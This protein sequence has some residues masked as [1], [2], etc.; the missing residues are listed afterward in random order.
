MRS[1][2]SFIIISTILLRYH[3]TNATLSSQ[4]PAIDSVNVTYLKHETDCDKFYKCTNGR[5]VLF[6]CP[7]G[8]QFNLQLGVCDYPANVN[9]IV[10]DS[11]VVNSE[12]TTNTN[13]P[14]PSSESS[15]AGK[16]P[17]PSLTQTVANVI[18]T[19]VDLILP[20]E[21]ST[22]PSGPSVEINTVTVNPNQP[23]V[24]QELAVTSDSSNPGVT[25]A[26]V[27]G[28]ISSQ[29]VDT[30]ATD[31]SRP[32]GPSNANPS[33]TVD[34]QEPATTVGNIDPTATETPFSDT[35]SSQIVDFP[36]NQ[37][38]VG[39]TNTTS[40]N[41][42]QQQPN[43]AAN[44]S[45]PAT[46]NSTQNPAVIIDELN[47]GITNSPPVESTGA[48]SPN[49]AQPGGNPSEQVSNVDQQQPSGATEQSVVDTPNSTQNPAVI[50]DEL[51]PGI[52]NSPPVE[53]TGAGSPNV[54]Q[55]GGNPS[56]QA[57]NVDQQQ[58]SGATEQS[59]VDTPNS[60]QTPAEIIDELNP[61]ITNSLPVES[62]AAGSPNVAQ[63]GG[64]PSEQVS[65]VDQQQPS[66]ATEQSVVDTPNSTQNPAVIIDELNPGITNIPPAES[67]AAG[68]P[69]VAQPGGN[70]SEQVSNVDQQQPNGAS[71]QLVT[72]IPNS[73]QNPAVIIDELNPGITNSPPAE[74]TGAGSPNVAQPGSNPSEQVSNVD[75]QQP[76]VATNQ[77]IAANSSA[78]QNPGVIIDELNP[79]VSGGS[80]V[81][82]TGTGSGNAAQSGNPSVQAPNV[83]QQQPSVATNQSVAANSSTSQNPGVIIDELNPGVS[84]GSLVNS[85]ATGS[86]NAAQPGSNPSVQAPNVDQQ[87]PSVA[88]N[89][90]VAANSSASQNPGAII[91]ELNPGVS[92]GS[93]VNSTA[94]GSGN[95]AQPGSNPSVQ[96]PNV[97]QQQPSVATNQSVAA[98]S[99]A[100]QNPGAIIDELNPGVS[101]GSLVN[102]TGTGSGNA[103]QPSGG[104]SVNA[105]GELDSAS[106]PGSSSSA[107]SPANGSNRPTNSNESNND[108]DDNGNDNSDETSPKSKEN[109]SNIDDDDNKENSREN[110]EDE[111]ENKSGNK[112]NKENDSDDD[113]NESKQKKEKNDEDDSSNSKEKKGKIRAVNKILS[114]INKLR[115][116]LSKLAQQEKLNQGSDEDNSY[117]KKRGII[118][119]KIK[120]L[121]KKERLF[122]EDSNESN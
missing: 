103:A 92:G 74:S 51:N 70:P 121:V 44:P 100:S 99:S 119:A 89:Q 21:A 80:L 33:N 95:A 37:P 45:V 26:P 120:S 10:T 54:A 56:E 34:L 82:S 42:D 36:S 97:D 87:Q 58:P 72:D 28:T 39:S 84:G 94:T 25:E 6:N 53:S 5:A 66:G 9:C 32:V 110:S 12:S 11:V 41:V 8:L 13:T 93:L 96:A 52:T 22:T 30:L 18:T 88:T 31:A 116:K 83:D 77:S 104:T 113:S 63:P 106:H 107:Q 16:T 112:F 38:P 67:T 20:K 23:N 76:S 15:F 27:V 78:S 24:P 73:T 71:D 1:I 4:C 86:G 108:D 117:E 3:E 91:D 61:G 90:S 98:N 79:G 43:D 19:V 17:S 50:I 47:P 7:V 115:S 59:V 101:G 122:K 40:P 64:N 75:Q 109:N 46:L 60:T 118:I 69:N 81:N 29:L 48:G 49:V 62:T 55:P 111:T 65:N 105:G 14:L 2:Y 35:T 68:S 85:T 102:S 57:S 114:K